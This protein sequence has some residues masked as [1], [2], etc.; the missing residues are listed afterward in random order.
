MTDTRPGEISTAEAR[1]IAQEIV[2]QMESEQ[3]FKIE[4][5][6]K[7]ERLTLEVAHLKL[8]VD[9][10]EKRIGGVTQSID[11]S[12][13]TINKIIGALMLI[14]AGGGVAAGIVQLIRFVR[15]A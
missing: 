7:L 9:S 13:G 10:Q 6:V 15:G 8:S 3:D 12:Q 5:L 4:V 1:K 2:G 14:A 11:S